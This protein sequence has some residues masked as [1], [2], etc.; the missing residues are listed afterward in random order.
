MNKHEIRSV[1]INEIAKQ[2]KE[3]NEPIPPW[4]NIGHIEFDLDKPI[5]KDIEVQSQGERTM[6]IEIPNN[7]TN[8]DVIKA[9]FPNALNC[10][11]V[12]LDKQENIL[13]TNINYHWW[14]E[15]YKENNNVSN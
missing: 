10:G 3:H 6:T 11:T 9:L 5:T 12:M 15:S 8:G 14:L 1:F 4:L 2:Y 7:A 13:F